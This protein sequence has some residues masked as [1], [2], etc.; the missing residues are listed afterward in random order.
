MVVDGGR[1]SKVDNMWGYRRDWQGGIKC[2]RETK[3]KQHRERN[4]C[5]PTYGWTDFPLSTSSLIPICALVEPHKSA[6]KG[7]LVR[8]QDKR[9]AHH[10]PLLPCFCCCLLL[11]PPHVLRGVSHQLVWR[12]L[13][14]GRCS[15]VSGEALW[16]AGVKWCGQYG[17]TGKMRDNVR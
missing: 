3:R 2:E 16:C 1:E 8:K 11:F 7:K 5:L 12:L 10:R 4:L 15:D 17:K 14:M 6:K 13:L 9:Y